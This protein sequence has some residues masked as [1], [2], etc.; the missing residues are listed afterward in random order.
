MYHHLSHYSKWTIQLGMVI[1]LLLLSGCKLPLLPVPVSAASLPVV[2]PA[3]PEIP[4]PTQTA[5]PSP[6]RTATATPSQTPTATRTPTETP[7]PTATRTPTVTPTP[8]IT[9]T[10]GPTMTPTFDFPDVVV[11]EQAN[12]RYGAGTAY[13]Y[14]H[15]LYKGDTGIVGGRNFS[16]SWLWIMPNTLDR[17]CWVAASV[18]DVTGDV[19]TVLEIHPALPFSTFYYPP[20]GIQADRAGNQ[21]TVN[22]NRVPM[23]EDDD[24][25]YLIEANLCQNGDLV[26]VAVQTNKTSYTFT[27]DQNCSDKSNAR[28]YTVDK[29]GYS[30][31]VKINW[32]K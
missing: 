16:G 20:S 26:W 19:F 25:G 32:P 28:L 18:V 2:T 24:R 31:P 3:S 30:K 5:F 10:P 12:C 8:T 29:H 17:Y 9:P 22:W 4:E 14:S 1:L 23:T 13:L 27:D 6:T 21:V 15:G 7:D 11:K